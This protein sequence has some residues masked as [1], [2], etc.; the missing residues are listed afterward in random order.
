MFTRLVKG[1]DCC[2]IAIE[3]SGDLMD[4]GLEVVA[5]R[6]PSRVHKTSKISKQDLHSNPKTLNYEYPYQASAVLQTRS[7]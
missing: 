5:G 2:R 4:P 7:R 6:P 1:L 3:A